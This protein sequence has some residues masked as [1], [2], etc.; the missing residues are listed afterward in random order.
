MTAET[1]DRSS[2]AAS[3]KAL[4]RR[5]LLKAVG[6]LTFCAAMGADGFRLTAVVQAQTAPGATAASLNPWVRIRPDGTTLIYSAGA[7]MGQGTLTSLAAV[8][9]EEM[10]A[11]WSKVIVEFA[12][13]E[14]EVY[15]Y[16]S[17]DRR[18]MAITGSHGVQYY[19]KDMRIA[20]AQVRRVLLAAAA[21]HWKVDAATLKTEPHAVIDPTSGRRLS[22]GEI[23]AFA[24][25]PAQL[26]E[27]ADGD[28]KAGGDFRLIGKTQ[29]R[30]DI[31]AK[32]NGSAVYSIDIHLPGMVYATSLHSPVHNGAPERWNDAEIKAMKGVLGTVK[33]RSGVAVV[34]ETWE[35]ALAAKQALQV[36]WAAAKAAEFDSEKVFD[37]YDKTHADSKAEAKSVRA[38]GD[39]SA[40]FAAAAQTFKSEFRSDF[41][42][43]ATME[44][45][46]AVARFNAAGDAV[47]VWDGTQAP[48][49][50]RADVARALG[51]KVEQVTHHQ[52]Y[53]GGGLGR[54]S[55]GDY[56]SETA[57]IARA[58]N[59][60]V[61]LI[62]TREEDLAFG[63]FR[64]QT[65]QCLEA[66]FD[67]DGNISGWRH[68]VVGDGG[69]QLLIGGTR[70]PNYQVPHQNIEL[71]PLSHGV[72][73][74]HWRGVANVFN[75]FAVESFVD[76]LAVA[77]AMD[78]IDFRVKH[79]A[80]SRRART[81]ME[82][83]AAMSDWGAKRGDG[84]VLGL[85]LGEKADS[86]AAGVVEISLDR[87]TGKIHVHKV[88]LAVD[89][90]LIVQPDAAKANLESGILQGLSSVLHERVTLKDGV[91]EQSNFHD[92]HLL[93]MEDVPEDIAIEFVERDAPPAGLGETGN[94]WTASAIA[95]AFY[96]LTGKRLRHMP[97]TPERVR[98]LLSA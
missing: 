89:G 28:L 55:V 68:C 34:A 97:F 9:A 67:G 15:G 8:V 12:P 79:M 23:A 74:K 17:G 65:Y 5:G 60:P 85:S 53:M 63:M 76:E 49:R 44:P 43:H 48:D 86:V 78:P 31:P 64:P 6:G 51:F 59:R 1:R 83:V 37:L 81:V 71:R 88:W 50:C 26:P 24:K 30:R 61:K 80:V 13:S 47:E 25:V 45:L 73:L 82:K 90:G 52:C 91:V 94:P 22:Y 16:V 92:Y 39:V 3:T 20:G 56:A 35:N 7:E 4:S 57:L 40:A 66:A 42:Y 33:L 95:N 36:N 27:I 96:R 21:E 62:W 10:D 18:S 77:R 84:R 75:T 14:A 72:R 38:K 54:R 29:P 69:T 87:G 32:V 41:G 70:L 58:V 11:D 98:A 2:A 19:Y 46:N 93:R